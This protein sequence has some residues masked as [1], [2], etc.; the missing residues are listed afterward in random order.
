MNL[1]DIVTE[2][3]AAPIY[4]FS[5]GMLCDPQYMHGAQLVGVAELRNFRFEML[6]YANV[7]P[8]AGDQ[9]YGCLWS[10]DR[11]MLRELD[12][13]E[14]YP[15]LYDRK[16]VPAYVDGHKYITELYTMTP[17]SRDRLQGSHPDQ[18]YINSIVRGYNAAGVP[19]AQLRH[20]L[21]GSPKRQPR[22]YANP[23][24]SAEHTTTVD[25]VAMNP[26]AYAQSIAQGQQQGV[27]I[28]FEF[29]VCVPAAVFATGPGAVTYKIIDRLLHTQ[30]LENMSLHPNDLAIFDTYFT[31][32]PGKSQY[33]TF[34]DALTAVLKER[35]AKAKEYFY[36]IPEKVRVKYVSAAKN[37]VDQRTRDDDPMKPL[38]FTSRLALDI[39]RDRGNIDNYA[40][41]LP[42]IDEMM[43]MQ[44]DADTV[45]H[46]M[47]KQD[48]W[49]VTQQMSKYFDYDMS[50]VYNQYGLDEY[51]ND[52][53]GEYYPGYGQASKTIAPVLKT[54]MG[55]QVVIFQDRHDDTKKL[56]RWY[57]EPDGSLTPNDLEDAC[58]EIVGPPEPPNTALD[59]LQKFFGMAQQMKFYTNG[60]T[61]L[62][63]NVSIP[64][65]IDVLKLAVFTGDQHVLQQYGRLENYYA[66][67]VTRDLGS[68][69]W[70][71]D[72]AYVFP[73][74]QQAGSNVFGQKKLSRDIRLKLIQQIAAKIS[75][76]HR[77]S[78]SSENDKYI[79]FRHT[80]GDYLNDY[81]GIVNVVGRFVRAMVIAS[82][83][84]AYR[85][86]Y[87]AAV[88]KMAAPAMAPTGAE[89]D[90]ARVKREG[91][92]QGNLYLLRA[93]P[94][95]LF[96]NVLAKSDLTGGTFSHWKTV[97]P[98]EPGSEEAKQ[99]FIATSDRY[100]EPPVTE[101]AKVSITT[102]NIWASDFY[103]KIA[104]KGRV[105][106][107]NGYYVLKV[108]MIP[109][110]DP[111]VQ[112]VILQMRKQRFRE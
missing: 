65:G 55:S 28:G 22:R 66:Q 51:D 33:P 47:F 44:F 36:Q 3:G 41:S 100:K 105:A 56:D 32:K 58:V 25:E 71:D 2:S 98:I 72:M 85:N 40:P 20:S 60:T 101:F 87:L 63:I 8:A 4:Y 17:E 109:P 24:K 75:Q 73:R 34:T 5:Y 9:V 19:L 90:I 80:G 14:G 93:S 46:A 110:T 18:G 31:P 104:N 69:K 30:N 53:E 92:A 15:T 68:E 112:Q 42:I 81:Q 1:Y 89:A 45:F 13:I 11:A 88:A 61:G 21:K 54:T 26:T 95:V 16:T 96:K 10:L 107:N 82:D 50:E 38:M 108:E 70:R 52:D 62:H 37:E 59:S 43:Q 102:N 103:K 49:H 39:W 7:L 78:I 94:R 29:E 27:K 97:G 35:I 111:H 99:A 57:I 74:K 6:Q 23:Y 64:E 48:G 67:S 83:P 79:S 86:E 12:Q 91:L 84:A 106:V 77:A 76:S